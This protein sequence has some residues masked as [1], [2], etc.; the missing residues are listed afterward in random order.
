MVTAAG[1]CHSYEDDI[2]IENEV[3]DSFV[4]VVREIYRNG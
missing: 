1:M 4:D 3:L 2:S